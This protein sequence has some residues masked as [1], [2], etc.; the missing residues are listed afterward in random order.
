LTG[1]NYHSYSAIKS[2]KFEAFNKAPQMTG[3]KII[4]GFYTAPKK[5]NIKEE[6]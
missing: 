2:N 6:I 3:A 1:K 5:P 4:R